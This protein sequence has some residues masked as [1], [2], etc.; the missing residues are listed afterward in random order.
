MLA[1][2]FLLLNLSMSVCF[3]GVSVMLIVWSWYWFF[4][5]F[6]LQ[7]RQL[8]WC[9][10]VFRF[11]LCVFCACL[12]LSCRRRGRRHRWGTGPTSCTERIS[13][14]TVA[15]SMWCR[16]SLAGAVVCKKFLKIRSH[17]QFYCCAKFFSKKYIS[18]L[19]IR[20]VYIPAGTSEI[21]KFPLVSVYLWWI[22]F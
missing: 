11:I 20:N 10:C 9:L 5:S 18:E 13:D 17:D 4:V 22:W 7:M 12:F 14:R 1:S 3:W 19:V 2:A 15:A 16:V 8:I 6:Y 21:T